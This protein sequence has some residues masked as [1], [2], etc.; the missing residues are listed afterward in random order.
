MSGGKPRHRGTV[1]ILCCS[2]CRSRQRIDWRSAFPRHRQEIAL[3]T[4]GQDSLAAEAGISGFAM[5][6]GQAHLVRILELLARVRGTTLSAIPE[7]G[8]T[9]HG[10]PAPTCRE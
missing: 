6:T 8:S 2:L 9:S 10:E 5:G 3:Y 1:C 7:A 4:N